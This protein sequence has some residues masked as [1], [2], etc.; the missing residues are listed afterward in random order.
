MRIWVRMKKNPNVTKNILESDFDEQTM[1][2]IIDNKPS[3][4]G[5]ILSSRK[6]PGIVSSY[7][8]NSSDPSMTFKGKEDAGAVDN[9]LDAKL[10]D[11][12]AR[13]EEREKKTGRPFRNRKQ[14]PKKKRR[15]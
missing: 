10:E 3:K 15:N 2:K 11:A 6:A 13:A 1:E 9:Y 5:E 8:T 12:K 7:N 4:L 14:K